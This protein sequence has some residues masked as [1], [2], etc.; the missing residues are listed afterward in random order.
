VTLT[1][2]DVIAVGA[3][4]LD[5]EGIEGVSMRKLASALG[6][7]PATLYWHVRD[8]DELLALILDDTIERIEVPT[9]GRWDERLAQILGTTRRALLPRPILVHVIWEAGWHIGPETLR[10]ADALVACIAESGLP[11]DQVADAYF[12]LVTF[13]LGFVLAE[14]STVGNP[15][16]GTPEAIDDG[17]EQLAE[18]NKR[19]PHLARY[20]PSADL[21]GMERRFDLGVL[22]FTE[23]IKARARQARA[24]ARARRGR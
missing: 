21:E 24:A 17:E 18:L 7:G 3:Q 12:A 2:E 23:G 14:T 5:A 6:T 20:G 1:R 16:F 15:R 10:V 8:K 4:L 19:F 22:D 11:D 13:V 9:E